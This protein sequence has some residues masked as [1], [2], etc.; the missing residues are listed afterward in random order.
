M[1]Y[2]NWFGFKKSTR[3]NWKKI[4]VVIKKD[5]K[6]KNDLISPW[7]SFESFSWKYFYS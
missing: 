3:K 6:L 5:P 7:L 1:G 2:N 4:Q